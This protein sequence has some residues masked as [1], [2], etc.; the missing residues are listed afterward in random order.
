MNW[1][2]CLVANTAAMVANGS[3]SL[4]QFSTSTWLKQQT[5][6]LSFFH[7]ACFIGASCRYPVLRHPEA[8]NSRPSASPGLVIPAQ[9][10]AGLDF[11]LSRCFHQDSVASADFILLVLLMFINNMLFSYLLACY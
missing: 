10:P 4:I 8:T 7:T 2:G 9:I 6:A 1:Q 5:S 3:A 11:Q